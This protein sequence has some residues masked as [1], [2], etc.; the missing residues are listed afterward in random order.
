MHLICCSPKTTIQETVLLPYVC[1]WCGRV[2]KPKQMWIVGFAAERVGPITRRR[3][4]T[5]Y[6]RWSQ[7]SA[8]H[9]MAVHF[10][11]EKHKDLYVARIL[12]EARHEHTEVEPSICTSTKPT[13]IGTSVISKRVTARE[14][15][16]SS[17]RQN[18]S[19]VR[20]I[21]AFNEADH[22]RLNGMGVARSAT[23][24]NSSQQVNKSNLAC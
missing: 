22:I 4:V 19:I 5:I 8:A 24:R 3:E 2:R 17:E 10:C 23:N 20:T 14:H 21:A 7:L 1:D 15:S 9:P 6:A 12:L 13:S 18:R 11:S 16:S